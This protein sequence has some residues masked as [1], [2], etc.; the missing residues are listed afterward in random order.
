MLVLTLVQAVAIS[1]LLVLL[2]L[3]FV[4][5][6]G[7]R[8]QPGQSRRV[9]FYFT[10]IGLAFLFIEIAFIQ[11]FILF[12]ADP[13]YAVAVVLCGFLVFSGSGSLYASRLVDSC[14]RKQ[15]VLVVLALAIIALLY[16]WL[17]P[18]LFQRA[19]HLAGAIKVILS[20]ILIAP[21]AFCMGMPFPL[22]LSRVDATAPQLVPWA[23]AVNG[24]AS[25]ISAILASLLAIHFGFNLVIIS[26]LLLYFAAVLYF[27][28]PAS[29]QDDIR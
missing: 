23:W 29:N 26:A 15:I 3:A 6:S 25:L 1:I 18:P 7:E 17:L 11:K 4:R 2:P 10:A 20:L 19:A 12:L 5:R 22:G 27:P 21:P 16:L 13:I 28:A 8:L 14:Q 9:L 24:C